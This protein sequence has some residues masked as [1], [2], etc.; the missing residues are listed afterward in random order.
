[1]PIHIEKECV[2]DS[3]RVLFYENRLR[4]PRCERIESYPC[5]DG[6]IAGSHIKSIIVRDAYVIVDAIECDSIAASSSD[7]RSTILQHASMPARG[8]RGRRAT[9][10]VERPMRS[11]ALRM[12]IS[13]GRGERE[14]QDKSCCCLYENNKCVSR[15]H[16]TSLSMMGAAC[17]DNDGDNHFSASRTLL[18][19]I[20]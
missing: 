6:E 3:I 12:S 20:A 8:I 4:L 1:M 19:L 14:Q 13:K 7:P 15:V 11:C 5:R 16:D 9:S 18:Q 10:F 2:T 17:K